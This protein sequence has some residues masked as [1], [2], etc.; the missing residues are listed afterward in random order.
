[1]G[2]KQLPKPVLK[3]LSKEMATLR[4]SGKRPAEIAAI[5]NATGAKKGTG[6]PLDAPYVVN[7]LCRVRSG[8]ASWYRK[9]AARTAPKPFTRLTPKTQ[10]DEILAIITLPVS[11]K[12]QRK[13]LMAYLSEGQ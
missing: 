3:K 12:V 4:A 7:L 1:M 8:R 10:A 11:P 5:L 6:E 9:K 2:T 13:L